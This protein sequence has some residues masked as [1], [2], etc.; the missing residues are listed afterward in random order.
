MTITANLYLL[1]YKNTLSLLYQDRTV[2]VIY[3][4]N[5]TK[6]VLWKNAEYLDG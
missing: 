5:H 4:R 3:Y 2:N 1:P 6:Y